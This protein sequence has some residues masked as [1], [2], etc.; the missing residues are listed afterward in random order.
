MR[1]LDELCLS[2]SRIIPVNTIEYAAARQNVCVIHAKVY[3]AD[4]DHQHILCIVVASLVKY[5]FKMQ[6]PL[7]HHLEIDYLFF[8]LCLFLQV[9]ADNF[10]FSLSYSLSS[11]LSSSFSFSLFVFLSAPL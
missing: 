3:A 9:K 11:S 4:S 1:T 6:Q 10:L 7:L 8:C 2:D 5:H